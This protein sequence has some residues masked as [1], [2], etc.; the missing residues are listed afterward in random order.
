MTESTP[1]VTSNVSVDPGEI[2][3][4]ARFLQQM[5]TELTSARTELIRNRGRAA[6]AFGTFDRADTAVR[7]HDAALE[8]EIE[9]LD[10][11]IARFGELTEG[12]VQLSRTYSDLEELN[13]TTGT[14]ISTHLSEGGQ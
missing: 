13:R 14:Q 4:F 12:T 10:A 5:E 11:L 2:R 3:S 6:R 8:D 9:Y 7:K 1:P